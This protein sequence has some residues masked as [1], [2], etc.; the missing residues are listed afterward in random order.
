[1]DAFTR[2]A[3]FDT[4]CKGLRIVANLLTI[5]VLKLSPTAALLVLQGMQLS[6]LFPDDAK[7][8]HTHL[9]DPKQG[10]GEIERGPFILLAGKLTPFS[11]PMPRLLDVSLAAISGVPE[12]LTREEVAG[13]L[14][15]ALDVYR[16]Y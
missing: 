5:P 4:T 2:R 3:P 15:T 10:L 1:M 13:A 9:E 6:Q 14:L 11:D 7:F 16:T 8:V 12:G